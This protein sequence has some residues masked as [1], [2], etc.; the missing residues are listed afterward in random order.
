MLTIDN[1]SVTL[2]NT[3]ILKDLSLTINPGEIVGLVAPNG[4]GKTT[5]LKTIV[6]L[7]PIDAGIISI[8]NT[9]AKTE[10]YNRA[11]FSFQN[12]DSLYPNLNALD[13]LTFVKRAWK[14]EKQIDHVI[15]QL[16]MDVYKNKK[17]RQLSL[18]MKQHVLLAMAI[19]SD[20]KLILMDEP[21]NG[22]DPS[23]VKIISTIIRSMQSEGT[24]FLFSSHILNH[25]DQLCSK[26]F[27]LKD[28]KIF[29]IS[30]L[31]AKNFI[32]TEQNYNLL[33]EGDTHS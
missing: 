16:K 32:S 29:L 4:S 9:S 11:L 24:S 21:F 28:K 22:L 27:F 31:T 5:L 17:I 30:D 12:A 7:N 2:N 20:A 19:I 8:E 13:H 15:T 25:I 26:V 6:K 10:E 33:F 18:G 1:I 3:N 14:S 23:S